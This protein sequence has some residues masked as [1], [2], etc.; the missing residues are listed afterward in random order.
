MK[1]IKIAIGGMHCASCG[2][3]IERSIKKIKGVQQVTINVMLKKGYV[4]MDDQVTEDAIKQAVTKT[5]Y[6]VTTVEAA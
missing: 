1:K 6:K 5:G 2:T 4:T 3:N